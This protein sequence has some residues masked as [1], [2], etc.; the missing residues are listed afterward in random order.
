M[1]YPVK[2]MYIVTWKYDFDFSAGNY[3]LLGRF[4]AITNPAI[5]TFIDAL[6]HFFQLFSF[7]S[8]FLNFHFFLHHKYVTLTASLDWLTNSWH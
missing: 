8:L 3:F 5:F 1:L 6:I 4:E 2:K 7:F